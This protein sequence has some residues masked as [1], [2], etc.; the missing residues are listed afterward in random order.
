MLLYNWGV[1]EREEIYKYNKYTCVMHTQQPYTDTRNTRARGRVISRRVKSQMYIKGYMSKRK[2]EREK[3]RERKRE[4]E[5]EREKWLI[6]VRCAHKIY[7]DRYVNES[8][9]MLYVR[10][11]HR[12]MM[13]QREIEQSLNAAYVRDLPEARMRIRDEDT[14]KVR[15]YY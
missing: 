4:R 9:Y 12:R 14:P 8:R 15:I 1:P 7:R 5:R 13:R 6:Y 2:K 3:E 11:Y 10:A